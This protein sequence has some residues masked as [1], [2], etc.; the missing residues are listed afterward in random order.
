MRCQRSL[1]RF[2][3]LLSK[4]Y[5][6]SATGESTRVREQACFDAVPIC[7][8][9]HLL[10]A[11]ASSSAA[12]QSASADSAQ[13]PSLTSAQRLIDS[14]Q[15]DA[16]LNELDGIAAAKPSTVGLQYLR[17]MVLYQQGKMVEPRRLRTGCCAEPEGFR[18]DA[19]GRREPVSPGKTRRGD[20]AA[21]AGKRSGAEYAYRSRL[22]I[23]A[24]LH[25]H[26][27]LRRRPQGI[28]GTVRFRR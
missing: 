7:S 24:L 15:L 2:Q 17:G 20:P 14:G 8:F 12:G 11:L 5:Y 16:A 21:G 10:I 27:S 13:P 23:G 19:D 1:R 6:A 22:C 18:I 3:T 28:L 25:G 26:P 4:C 9:L